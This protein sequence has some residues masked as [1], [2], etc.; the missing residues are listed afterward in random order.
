M[1]YL[2]DRAADI[3]RAAVGRHLH[4][5]LLHKVG[6]DGRREELP[7]LGQ[8]LTD[9][10]DGGGSHARMRVVKECLSKVFSYLFTL[11]FS[12]F[13]FKNLNSKMRPHHNSVQLILDGLV[14]ALVVLVGVV[15]REGFSENQRGVGSH[16]KIR[17]LQTPNRDVKP[18]SCIEK[19]GERQETRSHSKLSREW[20]YKDD[21]ASG[22][23]WKRPS[24][25]GNNSQPAR[26]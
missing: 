21:R 8:D 5:Q 2:E 12:L 17:N 15:H 24:W 9:A 3:R 4:H 22:P 25:S 20:A 16:L 11:F 14:R 13:Q 1:V 19:G 23:P 26:E 10:Q 6:D 18:E 7:A